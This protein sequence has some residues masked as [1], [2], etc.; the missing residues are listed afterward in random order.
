MRFSEVIGHEE[1]K[2][3]LRTAADTGRIPHAILLHGP[4]GI[5]KTRLARAF[6]QYINCTER[7]EGDSCGKCP[8]CIQ[9]ASLNNP[10]VHYVYP[11]LNKRSSS[12]LSSDYAEEWKE[13]LKQY[14][15]MSPEQWQIMIDAGN[16]QPQI[17]VDESAEIIRIS[18][19][20]T[21]GARY[22]IF[23]V[24]LPEKMNV[25][26]AN[27][28]LK[29]IEEPFEDTLFIFVSNN[30]GAIIPTI[31]SR[32]QHVE[33][34]PLPSSEIIDFLV[35]KGKSYEEAEALAKIA[36]GNMNLASQLAERGNENEEFANI[37]ID[38]MR[39]AYSR[40]VTALR[41]YADNFA[42]FGREKSMRLLL[43]FNRML[44]ESF[45][46]NF[47]MPVLNA[48]TPAESTFVGKFGPFI[49]ADNIERL[50]AAVDDAYTD[51]SR[52]ANQKIVWFDLMLI[53]T[54]LIRKPK[55]PT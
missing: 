12:P 41:I 39:A 51:V 28:L 17:Y 37:F 46:S 4:S 22:K 54:Q 8:A 19:L 55:T 2:T 45:I 31:N 21:Y 40:N 16:S 23:I 44:R 10:D 18:S 1:A 49:N 9:T 26:T 7:R 14:S 24:W 34:N 25:S 11:I 36:R 20:S 5:G 13:M 43:Y 35:G 52:N 38:V 33:L 47:K 27:K 50:S 3:R 32:L 6:A 53:I 30:P 42:A 29:V 15:Y 48:M